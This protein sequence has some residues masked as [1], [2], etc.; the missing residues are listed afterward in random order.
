MIEHRTTIRARYADTDQMGFVY[1]ARYLEW[2][3]VGRTELLRAM[4]LPYSEIEAAG[5]ILPVIEVHCTYHR[6]ARY[7]QIVAIISRV[8][9]MPR[10]RIQID[11]EIFN[12]N[13]ELLASGYTIHSFLGTRGRPVRPPRTLLEKMRPHFSS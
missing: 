7:D 8:A 12:E 10:A 3:E 11:Y 9:R 5:I 13:D 6:P 4:G 2:F 1:Y